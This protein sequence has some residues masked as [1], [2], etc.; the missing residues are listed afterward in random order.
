MANTLGTPII[1]VRGAHMLQG[2]FS[3]MWVV[4]IPVSDQD[5]IGD[6]VSVTLTATV[7]GV[8]LGDLVLFSGFDKAQSDANAS[9][10]LDVFVSAANTVTV[11]LTNVDDATDAYDADVLTGGNLK[12]VIGRP[13]W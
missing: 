5:A 10:A 8:A 3:D 6:D 7:V 11:K 12:L 13:T 1:K 2:L 9:I 4:T